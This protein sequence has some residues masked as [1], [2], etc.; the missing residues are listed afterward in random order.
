MVEIPAK[1]PGL[2]SLTKTGV[3]ASAV[4]ARSARRKIG[5]VSMILINYDCVKI[6]RKTIIHL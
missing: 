3:W 6:L 1:T 4:L 2:M 5:L